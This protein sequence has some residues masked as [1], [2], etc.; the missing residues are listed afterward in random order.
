MFL[1]AYGVWL[2]LGGVV[3]VVAIIVII[4]SFVSITNATIR[5]ALSK[6]I[7]QPTNNKK[8]HNISSSNTKIIYLWHLPKTFSTIPPF[9]HTKRQPNSLCSLYMRIT[10][11]EFFSWPTKKHLILLVCWLLLAVQIQ[12]KSLIK[13]NVRIGTYFIMCLSL[14]LLSTVSI[15]I[16]FCTK[17]LTISIRLKWFNANSVQIR[18]FHMLNVVSSK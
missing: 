13:E 6:N 11:H 12:R 5:Q 10:S 8:Q 15:S 16:K 4:I 9:Y 14:L 2:V 7:Q 18:N 1:Y 3:D 17:W